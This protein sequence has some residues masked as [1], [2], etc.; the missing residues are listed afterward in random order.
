M[1]SDRFVVDAAALQ[2]LGERLIGRSEIALGELAKNSFDADATIC[3]IEFGDDQIVVTDDGIG[4]SAE[5]FVKYWMRLFTTH[6]IDQAT[7]QLFGRPLTGSKG[8]GRLS[9]QFLSHKMTL[10]ST[11]LNTPG[12]SIFAYI[13]WTTVKRSADLD[14]VQVQWEVREHTPEYP[15]NSPSGTRITL[16][17]LKSEWNADSIRELGANLWL[18]RS[19]FGHAP[20]FASSSDI[21]DFD[22]QVDAPGIS[23]AKTAFDDTLKGVLSNW[24]ARLTGVLKNGRSDEPAAIALEFRANYPSGL[25]RKKVFTETIAVPVRPSKQRDGPLIDAVVFQICIFKAKGRQARG[26][27]VADLRNYLAKFGNV[28]VYDAGFRLP[29]Y[30]AR[31]DQV[32][33]DWLSI[34][35]DQSR[36]LSMSELLPEKLQIK[37]RYMLDLPSPRRILGAVMIDTNHERSVANHTDGNSPR[38]EIQPGRDRLKDNEAFEQLRELVRYALH[39]YANR[40]RLLVLSVADTATRRR[41]PTTDIDRAID[42]VDRH[43]DELPSPIQKEL[44]GHLS[45]ARTGIRSTIELERQQAAL[46]APLATAG[47]AA[48]AFRHELLRERGTLKEVT[49][50]LRQVAYDSRDDR[51]SGITKDLNDF[52]D[53]L[54]S[55][56]ELFAPLVLDEDRDA[57]D[58]L[59]V[60][61]VV[62]QTVR[63]MRPLMPGVIFQKRSGIPR[64]LLF[65]L[66][67]WAEWNAIIQNVLAN[68]W[69][70]M[71]DC[72][73]AHI[74]FHGG[75]DRAGFDWVQI[76]DTGQGIGI[77]IGESD[78]LFEPFS[79]NVS[80]SQDRQSIAIGGQ[81][82]GLT[83]IRMIAHRRA[84]RVGFVPPKPGFATTFEMSWKRATQ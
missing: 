54:D 69:N 77:P 34:T 72:D 41:T 65:P 62:D 11:A 58:R 73:R 45:R 60:R 8:I 46:L 17:G 3:R 12:E 59:R 49:L 2:E 32:G 48:I 53:R 15:R 18:L 71:L 42:L 82:L 26:I 13:D 9:A 63:A 61:S 38:L 37:N 6:K 29:Y 84:V 43:K 7:S 74:A 39:Y 27:P 10:E 40:F 57:S 4:M 75:R 66:G 28:S 16:D 44:V 1:N 47:M 52:H 51:L 67:S 19:P 31:G 83:I 56:R 23:D 35:A 70:A 50:R 64:N 81:G 78:T 20:H 5:V 25:K 79:R 30:G 80:I 22:I 14:T 33:E 55:L 24:Q 36:R 68:S 76:S 21:P